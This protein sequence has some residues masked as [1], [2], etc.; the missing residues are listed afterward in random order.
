MIW[1]END[2]AFAESVAA[3]KVADYLGG[4][5]SLLAG[6][7]ALFPSVVRNMLYKIVAKTRRRL[8]VN[9][10]IPTPNECARFLS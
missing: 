8:P 3:M 1:V 4:R 7:V 9:C 2:Q 6:V 5:W 10:P